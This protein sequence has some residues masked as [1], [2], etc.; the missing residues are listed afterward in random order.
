MDKKTNWRR[1]PIGEADGAWRAVEDGSIV[2]ESGR[3]VHFTLG[4]FKR[5]I[6]QSANCFLCGLPKSAS[7][8]FNDEHVIPEWVLT[9]FRLLKVDR[10]TL[11]LPNDRDIPYGEYKM[12]CCKDCNDLLGEFAEGPMRT[13]LAGGYDAAMEAFR[14]KGHDEG[15]RLFAWL[16]LVFIK[17]HLHDRDFFYHK[18]QK[19]DGYARIPE[20]LGYE[21]ETFHFLH[22]V[23]RSFLTGAVIDPAAI[24]TV[25]IVPIDRTTRKA[26]FHFHSWTGDQTMVIQFGDFAVLT[27]LTDGEVLTPHLRSLF[28]AEFPPYPMPTV[29]S[30]AAR[31]RLHNRYLINRPRY[32]AVADLST[33]TYA[34]L[35][36][37]SDTRLGKPDFTELADIEIEMLK[38][39][40]YPVSDAEEVAMR[41]VYSTL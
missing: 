15:Q 20:E 12:R 36:P 30:I 5:E 9:K 14:G 35:G 10:E 8:P 23:A 34:L 6:C 37:V 7:K 2:A 27:V 17:A 39:G 25:L 4:R 21:W 11:F 40:G 16:A 22:A 31:A 26:D 3:T 24:G 32:N 13:R 41:A 33:R 18:N 28:E 19:Q 38:K 29:L 1:A